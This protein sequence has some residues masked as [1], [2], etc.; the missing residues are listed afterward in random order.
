MKYFTFFFMLLEIQHVFFTYCT[1]IFRL[2]ILQLI[3]SHLCLV[4]TVLG[5]IA[6]EAS[7]ESVQFWEEY[8]LG[9]L[10]PKV[11]GDT[12]SHY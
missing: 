8:F 7:S 5:S 2:A 9:V 12:T 6:P 11:F 10:P 4:G 3:N 1:F